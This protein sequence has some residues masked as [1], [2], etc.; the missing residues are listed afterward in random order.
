MIFAGLYLVLLF[1]FFFCFFFR[2]G[3][4][5]EASATT[6]PPSGR[7]TDGTPSEASSDDGSCPPPLPP[8]LPPPPA[9][10]LSS[11]AADQLEQMSCKIQ[12]LSQILEVGLIGFHR[13]LLNFTG[14]S[15]VS[16]GFTKFGGFLHC[17]WDKNFTFYLLN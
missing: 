10:S 7:P 5:C 17:F 14:F 15:W 11:E 1:F 8:P 13:V 12:Q 6:T 3:R 4:S 9:A 16:S 2:R